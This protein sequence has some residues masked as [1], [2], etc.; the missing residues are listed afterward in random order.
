MKGGAWS[1]VLRLLVYVRATL[2]L[3]ARCTV[4]MML[5]SLR[6]MPGQEA[7]EE[8]KPDY[9]TRSKGRKDETE[10]QRL[11]MRLREKQS[12]QP[13]SKRAAGR[14]RM[15][16]QPAGKTGGGGRGG[17]S[18]TTSSAS[19]P[20]WSVCPVSSLSGAFLLC[21]ASVVPSKPCFLYILQLLFLVIRKRKRL[22]CRLMGLWGFLLFFFFP[23]CKDI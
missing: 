17:Q 12:R 3:P 8:L 21:V 4:Q 13:L 20:Q 5:L 19:I 10:L 14:P 6:F 9:Q 15:G 22:Q 2:G 23:L 7:H 1:N 11:G 16:T 18:Q